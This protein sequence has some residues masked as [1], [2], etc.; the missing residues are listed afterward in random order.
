MMSEKEKAAVN[1]ED[2]SEDTVS[3]AEETVLEEETV[4]EDFEDQVPDET[5]EYEKKLNEANDKYLRCAAE[6]DNFRRRSIKERTDAA[7][8]ASIKC[9]TEFLTVIDNFER[10]LDAPCTDEKYK[11]GVRMIFNQ[12]NDILKKLGVEEIEAL[13]QPFDPNIHN[14]VNQTVDDNFPPNTVCQVF[15]KGYMLKGKVV[16]HPMVAV[17]N[18]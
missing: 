16:R 8:A 3:E 5:N 17:A 14:A 12:Y 1:G 2:N 10:A 13:N 15:C 18:P 9:I 4:V 11:D 7:D 6:Y